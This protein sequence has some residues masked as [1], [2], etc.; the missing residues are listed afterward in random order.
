MAELIC[1]L[2]RA[3]VARRYSKSKWKFILTFLYKVVVLC[4]VSFANLQRWS[5]LKQFTYFL[6]KRKVAVV[7][8]WSFAIFI[9]V[10]SL[11]IVWIFVE[12]RWLLV[13]AE[14]WTALSLLGILLSRKWRGN[15]RQQVIIQLFSII[16]LCA[17]TFRLVANLAV[18]WLSSVPIEL[19]CWLRL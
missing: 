13:L 15:S 4:C 17:A 7:V 10:F 2:K 5:E 14:L 19:L 9:L 1:K 12:R 3:W 18:D 16:W 8:G 11:I 6:E